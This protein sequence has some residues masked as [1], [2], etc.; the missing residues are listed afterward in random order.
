MTPLEVRAGPEEEEE[1]ASNSA[2]SKAIGP[3]E[4]NCATTRT[5]RNPKT[6]VVTPVSD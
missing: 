2:R 6:D 4:V 1:T 3:G 5:E